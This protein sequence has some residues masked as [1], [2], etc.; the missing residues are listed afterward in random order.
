[1]TSDQLIRL[2]SP[3]DELRSMID[4][5][6]DD[7]ELANLTAKTIRFY[8]SNLNRF[9]WWCVESGYPLDPVAYNPAVIRGFLRYIQ[10]SSERWDKPDHNMAGRPVKPT[11]VHAYYRT[12][13]RFFNWLV[14]QEFIAESP[15]ARIRPPRVPKE[16]PD[17]FNDDELVKLS[18]VLRDESETMLGSRNAAMVAVLLDAG[19]RAGELAAIQVHQLDI[20]NGDLYIAKGKGNKARQLRIGASARRRVRKYWLRW[21]RLQ[22]ETGPLFIAHGGGQLLPDGVHDVTTKL[23]VRAGVQPCNPH[24][25]RHTMAITSLRAGM[26]LLELQHILGHTSLDMVRHY[27]KIAET[28]IAAAVRQHSAL[29]HLKLNL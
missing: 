9:H 4:A 24:R 17:P 27:A 2:V 1:M 26:G 20:T 3:G 25:F 18:K 12:L 29:D 28:D 16:S 13:R 21:R 10:A 7:C 15:L 14:E 19:L 11:T 6:I 23:G 22:G 5:F 8:K